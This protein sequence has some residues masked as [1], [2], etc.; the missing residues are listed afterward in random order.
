MATVVKDPRN[1]SPFWYACFTTADGRR[2]KK[3]TKETSQ[4]KAKLIAEAM[5]RAEDEAKDRRLTEVRTRELLS[6]VLQR[7]SG[8]G[9]RIFTVAEWFDHFV[10]QKQKSRADKTALRHEQVRNE[11]VAF[12]GHR[13]SLN[14]ATITE[15]DI[16]GFRDHRESLGLAPSTLNGDVTILSAAFNAAMRQGHVRVNPCAVNANHRIM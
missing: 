2:L 1:R 6:D 14:I 15:K 16:A 8:M 11:F 5:Q 3:S 4:S 9:L 7:T 13:A 12:L 10:K